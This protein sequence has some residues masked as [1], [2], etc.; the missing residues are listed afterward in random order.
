MPASKGEIPKHFTMHSTLFALSAL[1]FA[2]WA[3]NSSVNHAVIDDNQAVELPGVLRYPIK[4]VQGSSGLSKRQNGQ[5]LHSQQHGLF[6]TIRLDIGTPKNTVDVQFDTGS[7]QLWVNP[8]CS[9]AA[10]PVDCT[11]L[12]RLRYSSTLKNLGKTHNIT[13]GMGYAYVKYV[14]DF[15]Q[16]GSAKLPN[17]T[18][19]VAIDSGFV[20]AGILG[21]GP[22]KRGMKKPDDFV[23]NSLHKQG[24]TKSIAFGVDLQGIA[25]ARGSVVFGGVDLK[26]FRGTLHATPILDGATA[27]DRT[28][29]YWINLDSI[30][31]TAGGETVTLVDQRLPVFLDTGAT[32]SYFPPSIVRKLLQGFPGAKRDKYANYIVN[33]SLRRQNASV[34][35]QFGSTVIRAAYKDFIY[36]FDGNACA[37]GFTEAV[38]KAYVLGD[39]FLRSAYVVFDQTNRQL[40]LAQAADC[41]TRL[42]AIGP[43]PAGPLV[44]ECG[45]PPVTSNTAFHT[46]TKRTSNKTSSSTK[47]T[48]TASPTYTST[49]TTT[50]IYAITTE[51][52]TSLTT[53]RPGENPKPTY[54]MHSRLHRGSRLPPHPKSTA[55]CP[56][57]GDCPPPAVSTEAP[58]RLRGEICPPLPT[59]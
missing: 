33:C 30:S 16:V 1:P 58:S 50:K 44:G 46:F 25:S 15:V 42:V 14:R 7:S 26:K 45:R 34:D 24:F 43:G 48:T 23:V 9:H 39:S 27:P 4:G 19:G 11:K 49:L 8:I 40:A 35:F 32:L 29:R 18:F 31:Q 22:S 20:S 13:Y 51:I 55:G 59:M 47:T 5:S 56:N 17:Q 21:V 6:Y 2:A 37:L 10:V 57:G 38:D 3:I 54:R 53:W 36:P 28:T 41:G 12:G 52:V